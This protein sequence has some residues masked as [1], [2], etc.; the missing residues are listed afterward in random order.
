MEKIFSYKNRVKLFFAVSKNDQKFKEK[1]VGVPIQRL[2]LILFYSV[3]F[4]STIFP[5]LQKHQTPHSTDTPLA[6]ASMAPYP[7]MQLLQHSRILSNLWPLPIPY[8]CALFL[9]SLLLSNILIRLILV[10]SKEF[11]FFI[12]IQKIVFYNLRNQFSTV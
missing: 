12:F 6:L 9:G 4:Y 5:S 8:N 2:S 3:F 7:P 1:D 10:S 11:Y